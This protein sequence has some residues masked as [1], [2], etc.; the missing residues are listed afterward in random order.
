MNNKG[1]GSEFDEVRLLERGHK[2]IDV[3]REQAH[4]GVVGDASGGDDHKPPWCAGQYMP[5]SE[6][7]IFGHHDPILVGS[8]SDLRIGGSVAVGKVTGVDGVMPCA[9]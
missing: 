6:V 7:A 9:D 8:P 5:V 1:I 4:Q 2:D 3:G